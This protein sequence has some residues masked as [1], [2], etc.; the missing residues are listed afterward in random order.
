MTVVLD[1]NVL[2]PGLLSPYGAPAHIVRMMVSGAFEVCYD[3]RILAEYEEVLRRSK[4]AFTREEVGNI[5][6]YIEHFGC[7][8]AAAPLLAPLR[9]PGDEPFL[10]VA[11]AGRAD[12][13]VTGNI[14]H[15]PSAARGRVRVV[16]PVQF[17]DAYR[18]SSG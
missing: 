6:G 1:T 4:F 8:V 15:Y 10:E 17:L 16:T 9:D 13:L 2:V 11:I 14:A 18:K 3:A 12:C 7:P 5:I